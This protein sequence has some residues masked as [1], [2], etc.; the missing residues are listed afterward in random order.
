MMQHTRR[1]GCGGGFFAA[2][3]AALLGA[4]VGAGIVWYVLKPQIRTEPA[5]AVERGE[6]QAPAAPMVGA[7]EEAV[8]AAIEKVGPAVVNISTLV[9]PRGGRGVPRGLRDLL[10]MPFEPFPR[11]GQ[12][13]GI[14]VDAQQGYVVTNTHVVKDASEVVV[15]LADGRRFPAEIV[16]MDPLS[17]I[18]VVKIPADGLPAAALG[19]AAA[20]SIG[21]W[22]V[23]IGNPFG[24]EN[25]VTVGVVSAKGRQ[26]AGP[27]GVTLSELLQTDAS[28]NPGNSGGA[29]V[30]LRGEVVGIPTAIIP[31][32]Q[33]I[34]F[35][36]S[37]DVASQV[38]HHLTTT[39]KMPWLGISHLDLP[40]EEAA[41]LDVPENRGSLVVATARRGPADRAG[42][43]EGDVIVEIAGEVVES[44]DELNHIIRSHSV[45]ERVSVTVIREGARRELEVELGEVPVG[46]F[47]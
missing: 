32:A 31:Y 18:A 28:I 19:S 22:V 1:T 41:R 17:E 13:S 25:S 39:G 6:Q 11:Q 2:F 21:S 33:G 35:A 44:A 23:A 43:E 40:P 9:R 20:L 36:V 34:G 16:G 7:P 3:L 24:Y 10:G 47:R 38:V 15:S 29:L 42:I 30:N 37:A 14:I 12:G 45:G 26:I 4:V 27:N 46:A 5:P 8:T